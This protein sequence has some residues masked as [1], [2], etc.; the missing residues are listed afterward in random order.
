MVSWSFNPRTHSGCDLRE[1]QTY[2][3]I[4][5][6]I[7]A[8][9]RGA[10]RCISKG[11]VAIDVS[12]HAPTRGATTSSS[13]PRRGMWMFQST[14]PLGVRPTRHLPTPQRLSVSIHAPTRGAT[15]W[16]SGSL[17]S[18]RCFNPRTL[19]GCDSSVPLREMS[20]NVSIHAP[21]RG[22]T[23]YSVID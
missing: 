4:I 3:Y 18:A 16:C 2:S 7:H 8:P 23:A 12:I 22:A 17:I 10:T 19:S 13:S 5:V 11:R 6:S 15:P 9:T 1:V 20:L 21:T 14:H